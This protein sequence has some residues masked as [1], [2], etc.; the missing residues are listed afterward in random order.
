[1]RDI[2]FSSVYFPAYAHIKRAFADDSGRN[3]PVS[4][5]VSGTLAGVPAA[6]LATPADVIKT[7]LQV[8]AR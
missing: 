5:L 7:R 6:I 2:G 8:C 1:M 3:S 4:L